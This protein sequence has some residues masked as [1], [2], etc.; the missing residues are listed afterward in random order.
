[1][2][3]D[4]D[5][6][7]KTEDRTI[8]YFHSLSAAG[9]V[10]TAISFGPA[11]MGFGLFVPDFRSAFSMSTSTV[12]FVSSLGFTG[13]FIGLLAAQWMLSRQG[14][15]APVLFGLAAASAGLATVA[16][17][18]NVIVLAVGVFL[19]AS[20]AG[21]AWTPF[22][23]A[24]HRKIEGADCA[25]ALSEISSGTSVGIFATGLAALWMVHAGISWRLCWMIFA[26]AALI[27]L[28][29]NYAVL[30]QIDEVAPAKRSAQKWTSLLQTVAAPLFAIAFVFGAT[31]A[32][33]IA[34][35]VDYM[36]EVGGIPGLS[37]DTTPA[38]VFVVYGLFGLTGLLTARLQYLIGLPWLV[39]SLMLA[40][41]LSLAVIAIS[42]G[43]WV[44]LIVSAGLQGVHVMGTSAVLA[45]WS[46]RL[47]PALPSFS[48]TAALLATAAGNVLGPALAGV[49]STAFGAPAMFLAAASLPAVTL[50][51]LVGRRTVAAIRIVDY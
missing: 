45:L 35:A 27:G 43:S 10:A 13:F 42:P 14:P 12:G 31:S 19:A 5:I 44:G 28:A 1:M 15:A 26:I 9:F 3:R 21:F 6:P 48:F 38:L 40:G 30:R 46:E 23:D 32:I 24:V 7:V 39:R 11:R 51:A 49:A 22:N 25:S 4:G 2:G 8:T 20:S 29:C 33:Y 16:M 41:A 47:F 34:F 50:I 37:K 36:A 18:P 17:A